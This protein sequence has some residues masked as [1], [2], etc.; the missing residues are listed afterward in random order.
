[1]TDSKP[2][3]LMQSFANL[4]PP[5][6]FHLRKCCGFNSPAFAGCTLLLQ[7]SSFGAVVSLLYLNNITIWDWFLSKTGPSIILCHPFRWKALFHISQFVVSVGSMLHFVVACFFMHVN[8]LSFEGLVW[9]VIVSCIQTFNKAF[10][11]K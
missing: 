6:P 9:F 3:T 8:L 1:M 4:H 7:S 2:Q 10:W 5:W 11:P